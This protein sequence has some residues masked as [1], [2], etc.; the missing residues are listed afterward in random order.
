[1]ILHPDTIEEVKKAGITRNYRD[2]ETVFLAGEPATG[3]YLILKGEAQVMKRNTAH[4]NQAV[5]TVREGET[6]GEVS[7]LISTPHTAT[8]VAKGD[9]ETVLLTRNRLD[10]VKRENPQLALRLYEM[11]ATTLARHLYE[12][13]W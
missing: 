2:G 11:L 1:M 6:M 13:P 7:L 3:M 8:V 12:R 4:Q 10:D 9:L 5:A